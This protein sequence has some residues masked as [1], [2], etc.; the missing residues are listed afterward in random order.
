MNDGMPSALWI[1]DA[2]VTHFVNSFSG[3]IWALDVLM[4][5]A[6]TVGIPLMVLSVACQWWTKSDRANSRHTLMSSGL[7]FILG[8]A[9]NQGVLLFV[10]RVRPYD[11]GVTHLLVS[12]SVDPSFPSDH[13]TAAFAIAFAMLA[14]SHRWRWGYLG[15]ALLIALS[16]DYLGL[17]Y[18][19]DLLGGAITAIAAVSF[20]L[21]AFHKQLKAA[22]FLSKL[23]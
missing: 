18:A 20:V 21:L 22:Q 19:S 8:L 16:R 12:P 10:N 6:S 9:L 23:F 11:A 3:Q 5:I 15:V 1:F 2:A 4:K 13:A 7:A 14:L 17:H